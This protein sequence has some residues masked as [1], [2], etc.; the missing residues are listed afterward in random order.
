VVAGVV[1]AL[2]AAFIAVRDVTHG[3]RLGSFAL[4]GGTFVHAGAP[5]DLPV[6][7]A[8]TGYDGQFY[9]RLALDPLTHQVTQFHITLDNPPYRQQRI[10]LPAL[11]WLVHEALRAPTSL[12]LV[13]V[14]LVAL[15]VVGF[16]GARLALQWNRSPWWGIAL[17]V[18][19]ALVM[20]LARDLTEPMAT[21]GLVVGLLWWVRGRVWW[22]AGAFTVGVLCRE[23]VL[24]LLFGMALWCVGQLVLGAAGVP[25]RTSAAK[26]GA[27]CVPA[28]VEIG[29]QFYVKHL[30]GGP[31]PTRSGHEQVGMILV[32][33]LRTLFLYADQIGPTHQG[34]LDAVWLLER[35][36]LLA[37]LI[38]VAS[39]LMRSIAPPE[40]GL[41][42]VFA[43][44][45]A[46]SVAWNQDV[47][48]VRA[49]NEAIIVGQ[50]L[51]LARKDQ[52]AR[53]T[54]AGVAGWS[55]MVAVIYAA[56]L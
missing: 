3:G 36:V 2:S 54:A 24:I 18:S 45:L 55:A 21:A 29:W 34:V 51:L 42:W 10:G 20:A 13:L 19:P 9:Y 23:T 39:G 15:V 48:F 28:A 44:L 26:V 40:I 52:I 16:A 12:A 33:P 56:A 25:R 7:A 50:L 8:S 47:Q 1:G 38:V 30:W 35:F 43:A 31:L 32:R 17:A 11:A 41:G 14:N 27:L 6:R 4:A 46:T 49:A 22:A 37:F 53:V 5:G